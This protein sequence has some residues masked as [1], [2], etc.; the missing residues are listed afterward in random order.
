MSICLPRCAWRLLL[1][2][3]LLAAACGEA[4]NDIEMHLGLEDKT[5]PL[6]I[7]CEPPEAAPGD[8]VLVTLLLYTPDPAALSVDWR[9]AL[10]YTVGPYG[11]EVIERRLVPLA[12]PAPV[13]EGEGFL[14]QQFRFVVPDSALLWASAL[15]DPLDDPAMVALAAAQLPAG[16]PLPPAKATVAAY[17]AALTAADLAALPADRQAA[18]WGLADRFA[19]RI[20]FRAAVA[21]ELYVEV[22]RSLTVRHSGRLGSPNANR[23][24]DY[25]DFEILAIPHPDVAFAD[26]LLYE[27][28]LLHFP[29]AS[30]ESLPALRVTQRADWTYYVTLAAQ[31]QFYTSP[32]SGEQLFAEQS[33]YRWYYVAMD[34]PRDPYP[35]F[36]D[37]DGDATEMWTLD[38]SVRL[39]P[40]PAAGERR[41]RLVCCLRD[42]RP[43]WEQYAATPGLTLVMGE[44]TF[45][46]PAAPAAPGSAGD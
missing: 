16:T 6:A 17:L 39:E 24:P 42:S 4:F 14:S 25:E 19:S 43:E 28:E 29:F 2:G 35:L 5:R 27:D 46:P 26:R 11:A 1:P 12:P 18:V 22:T 15:S 13:D 9:V 38:E 34:D 10:D 30:G 21:S 23:N 41:Y 33:S 32:Y 20:R 45:A 37:D 3:L 7:L 40:P 44:L 8:T 36:R 31:R